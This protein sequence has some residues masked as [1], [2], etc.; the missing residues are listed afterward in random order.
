MKKKIIIIGAGIAGLSAGCYG[1]M[2]GYETRIFE[3]HDIPGG[4]CTSWDRKGYRMDGCIHFLMGINP[5]S[6]FHS[7]W[8]EV[9]AFREKELVYHDYIMQIENNE[10]KKLTMYSDADKLES[11]LLEL[12]VRDSEVIGELTGAIRRFKDIRSA[13]G[14]ESLTKYYNVTMGEFVQRFKDPFL[15]EAFL[16]F[17]SKD[18]SVFSLI[19]QLAIY[20]NRDACWPVGGSLEFARGIERRYLELGGKIFYKSK[21]EEVLVSSDRA[22]GIRLAD[23]P[24]HT[25]DFVVSSAD[26]YSSIF[27]MVKGRYIDGEIKA[28]YESKKVSGTSIQVSLGVDCDLSRY[29]YCSNYILDSPVQI[30]GVE[31]TRI[32]IKHYCFDKTLCLPGKSV[33]TSL[34]STDYR[35][36][37]ELHNN[38]DN[39]ARE[40]KKVSDWFISLFESKFP[41]ARGKIEVADVA[42]P[43]TYFRYTQV[44]QGAYQ[45]W[46]SPAQKIPNV[47]PG[48]SGFYLAGQWT[49]ATGGLPTAVI[50]G[51][52]SI[53]R[54]C[55]DDG[56]KFESSC[57]S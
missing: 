55:R 28:L 21:V 35:Y 46:K 3:M 26:G 44:W 5:E 29:P 6:M 15:R 53:M 39:Y 16:A 42:T 12:S 43:M 52:G 8:N 13:S 32:L 56:K 49:Q 34:I 22:V 57:K 17:S 33:V 23:G 45:G 27:K 1:Q 24:V 7:T 37:E 47:L 48:L 20:N 4:L 40:K 19:F 25:A 50:S 10:G 41:E 11:H 18:Y 14:D 30:G 54:I 38:Y 51:K 31:N 36:W 9:G 2:N